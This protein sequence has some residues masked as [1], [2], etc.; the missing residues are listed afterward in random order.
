MQFK[1]G[2]I[3]NTKNE[4]DRFVYFVVKRNDTL[5]R[6]RL[7]KTVGGE[8][9]IYDEVRYI[10]EYIDSIADSETDIVFKVISARKINPKAPKVYD[11]GRRISS[12]VPACIRIKVETIKQNS[13]VDESF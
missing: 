6:I 9:A 12:A 11:F 7:A 3:I 10:D 8:Y 2:M 13:G 4:G 1:T 5:V